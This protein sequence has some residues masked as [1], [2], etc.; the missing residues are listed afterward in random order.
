MPSITWNE[1]KNKLVKKLRGVSF[2]QIV[3][4]INANKTILVF[5]HPNPKKYPKQKMMVVNINNYAYCVPFIANGKHMFLK[6]IYASRK[7]TKQY[8]KRSPHVHN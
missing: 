7:Y 8:I 4:A 1:D 3:D 2:N 6:T 5:P